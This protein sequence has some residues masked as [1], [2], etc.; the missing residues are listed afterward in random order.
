MRGGKKRDWRDRSR[1]NLLSQ[2]INPSPSSLP[3]GVPVPVPTPP[4]V[5]PVPVP[6][7][8]HRHAPSQDSHSSYPP[9]KPQPH[10]ATNTL[11][12]YK[13]QPT[14]FSSNCHARMGSEVVGP[15]RVF[16][17]LD[18]GSRKEREGRRKYRHR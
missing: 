1:L 5:V 14:D 13:A 4:P 16:C 17:V 10:Q 12:V 3:L 8:P 11:E 2:N 6:T 9:P 18:C 7:P 15:G